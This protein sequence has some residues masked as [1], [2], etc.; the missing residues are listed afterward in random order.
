MLALSSLSAS[1]RI[2]HSPLS[3][4]NHLSTSKIR[5]RRLITVCSLD[6]EPPPLNY[7]EIFRKAEVEIKKELKRKREEIE[8]GFGSRLK[9]L[10][11]RGP[12]WRRIFFASRK[13]RS[14][15]ILNVLTVIYG[16]PTP[17][18]SFNFSFN[19]LNICIL[20]YSLSS[21]LDTCLL[22]SRTFR[23]TLGVHFKPILVITVQFIIPP[24]L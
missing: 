10:S 17:L 14:L 20:K 15:M 13:V 24:S 18:V 6:E 22:V 2:L 12:L 16:T 3:R 23:Q 11:R 7:F 21:Y 19:W 4:S 9:S 5:L 8:L 1:P